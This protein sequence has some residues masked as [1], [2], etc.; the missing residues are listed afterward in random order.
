[1]AQSLAKVVLHLVFATKNR[2]DTIEDDKLNLLHTYL[3]TSCRELGSTV[4]RVGGT[5][6]H[7]HIATTLPRTV[8]L[9][10]MLR[11]IKAGSSGWMKTES[12]ADFAWQPGYGAFS[13][14]MSQVEDLVR[15]IDGQ[16]E[17]HSRRTFQ[18]E[19]L[20]LLRRYDVEY[21]ER[22]LWD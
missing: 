14:G 7:V 6:N 8:T 1:M 11:K 22:Y 15:Y 20:D 9:S 19:Y 5:S 2:E 13:I 12:R 3:A 4:L 17:H 21:D 10:D 18:E 16:Q